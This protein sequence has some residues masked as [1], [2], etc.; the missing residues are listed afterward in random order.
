MPG[1][2]ESKDESSFNSHAGVYRFNRMLFGLLNAPT[3]FQSALEVLLNKYTW[4]SCI[5]YLNEIIMFLKSNDQHLKYIEN[6]QAA[7][8]PAGVSL[9]L[10]KGQWLTTK[11][12]YLRYTIT[13]HL[14]NI[15]E[16]HTK[17]LKDMKHLRKLMELCY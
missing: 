17:G 15:T 5:M 3:T 6:I 1:A 4:N 2:D 7:L 16:A 8:F 11:V 9:N 14:F 13:P 10:K 12:K